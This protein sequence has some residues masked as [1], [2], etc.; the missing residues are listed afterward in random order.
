LQKEQCIRALY[1][2]IIK[3]MSDY[4]ETSGNQE[5]IL[6]ECYGA[7]IALR[8]SC[9]SLQ[10]LFL[11]QVPPVFQWQVVT[12]QAPDA[13]TIFTLASGED[14][15]PSAAAPHYVLHEDAHEIAK[16]TSREAALELL[17]SSLHFAVAQA[18]RDVVFVHAGVVGWRGRALI[19]P[20]RS[21]SGKTSL[22]AAL[23]KAG[24]LYLSDEY[25]VL[26]KSGLVHPYI[27]TLSLRTE[28]GER[29]QRTAQELGG[30]VA[31]EP[32]PVGLLAALVYQPNG[33]WNPRR[34]SAGEGLLIA[35]QNTVMARQQP[36]LSL[37]VLRSTML[38]AVAI[39]SERG[40]ADETAASLLTYMAALPQ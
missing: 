26:D 39:K 31:A 14:K 35:L 27:K 3:T 37:E 11:L 33:Q 25:A 38:G 13:D 10:A 30:H 21:M 1:H 12:G 6:L 17:E 34:L 22:V 16:T 9:A 36:A 15:E 29:L 24:A 5:T 19:L 18:A 40:D 7:R 23:V 4:V 28:T 2:R 8:F 20:G 32:L